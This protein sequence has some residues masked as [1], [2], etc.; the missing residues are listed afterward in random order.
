[1]S[2][3]YHGVFEGQN[4][5]GKDFVAGVL[6]YEVVVETGNHL[7]WIPTNEP[8]SSQVSTT[9]RWNCVTQ[10]HHNTIENIMMRDIALGRMPKVHEQ[11][12]RDNGYFDDNGK[13]NFAEGFNSILNE[14]VWDN[15]DPAKNGNYVWKV[16]EDG[17]KISGLIPA[18]MM[19]DVPTMKNAEY[20]NRS[21]ITPEMIAMGKEFLK[22]F[23]LPYE[24]QGVET[25]EILKQ[26]KQ[27]PLMITQPGHE[28][29]GVNHY[30][31]GLVINDSYDPYIKNLPYT[32]V[33]Y[34]M[35]VLVQYL[36]N[37]GDNMAKVIVNNGTISVQ[38]GKPGKEV[39]FS[40][41][42]GKETA[43]LFEAIKNSGE[44]ITES[45]PLGNRIGVLEDIPAFD[46]D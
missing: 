16:C 10:A 43:K 8:Q 11:W 30:A 7:P 38:F 29:V 36:I 13:I 2:K 1:M 17:R 45:S 22:R 27:S 21:R 26:M 33:R 37:V 5:N 46:L 6:P 20:Y 19:P 40:F 18:R 12:L 32:G 28:I 14:T 24:W 4:P 25:A 41:G 9:E 23:S 31:S 35:K 34:V 42:A 39:Y 3:I 44:D 15:P